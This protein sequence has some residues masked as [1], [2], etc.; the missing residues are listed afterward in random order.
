MQNDLRERTKKFALRVIRLS[1]KLPS[2]AP[3]RVIGQQVLR[4]G[5]SVGAQYREAFRAK[6]KADYVSK[7]TGCLQELEETQYWFELLIEGEIVKQELLEGLAGEANELIA[8]LTTIVLKV[9]KG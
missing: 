1:T 7:L 3:A 5:T 8:I 6:T 4:I 9:K 2:T